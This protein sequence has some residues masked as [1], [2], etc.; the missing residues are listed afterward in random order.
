MADLERSAAF[1]EN[2][3]GMTRIRT[4][5]LAYMDEIIMGF[6]DGPGAAVVLMHWTDGSTRD[7]SSNPVKLVFRTP[8]PHAVAERLVDNGG[9][10]TFGPTTVPEFDGATIGLGT[11]PDGYVIELI[12]A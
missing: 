9:S 4:I 7:Y 10:M 2:V 8:D 3:L 6:T 11:D 1:Y 12:G 5:R